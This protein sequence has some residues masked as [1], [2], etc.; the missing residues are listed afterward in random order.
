MYNLRPPDTEQSSLELTFEV[1]VQVNEGRAASVA[2]PFAGILRLFPDHVVM[3]HEPSL[4][5]E[6]TPG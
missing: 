5:A 3:A 4:R 1:Q 6:V 2:V